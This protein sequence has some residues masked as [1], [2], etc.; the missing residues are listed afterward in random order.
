MKI[1]QLQEEIEE[2]TKDKLKTVSEVEQPNPVHYNVQKKD[3]SAKMI[4]ELDI[5]I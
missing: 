2:R 3:L 1:C 4:F 5:Y